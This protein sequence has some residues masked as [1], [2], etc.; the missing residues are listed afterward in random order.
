MHLE[1]GSVPVAYTKYI[2]GKIGFLI[3]GLILL[4]VLVV[5][6]VSVG[7]VRIP[8]ADVL[9]TLMLGHVSD[10]LDVMIFNIRL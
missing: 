4:G 10:R 5:I 1:D 3:I 2:S 9:R 7:S 6:S 8:A